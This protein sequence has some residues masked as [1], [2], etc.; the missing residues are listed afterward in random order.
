MPT[1]YILSDNGE[2]FEIAPKKWARLVR[3]TQFAAD[4]SDERSRRDRVV[5]NDVPRSGAHPAGRFSVGI[6]LRNQDE[7]AYDQPNDML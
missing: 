6:R 4:R 3:A 7:A 2:V 1:D 5:S